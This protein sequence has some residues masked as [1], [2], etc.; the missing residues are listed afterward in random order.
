MGLTLFFMLIARRLNWNLYFCW[1][2]WMENWKTS[3][4]NI[5]KWQDTQENEKENVLHYTWATRVNKIDVELVNF[6]P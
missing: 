3:S 1:K 2:I 6:I 5:Y 4:E